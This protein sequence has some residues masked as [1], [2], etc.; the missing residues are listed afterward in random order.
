MQPIHRILSKCRVSLQNSGRGKKL[1]ISLLL[2]EIRP[3][4]AER[5]SEFITE[6]GTAFGADFQSFINHFNGFYLLAPYLRI[7]WRYFQAFH[8]MVTNSPVEREGVMILK[9]TIH[10]PVVWMPRHRA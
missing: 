7:K 4:V 6:Q 1:F 8:V 10:C 9:F 5:P 3:T 2:I